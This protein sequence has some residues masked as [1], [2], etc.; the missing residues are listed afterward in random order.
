MMKNE[1]FSFRKRLISFKYALKGI[2]L[3]F[4]YEHNARVHALI[5]TCSIITGF[6][7]GISYI[8][9]IAVILVIGT[10]LAAET[11][12]SA[13]EKLSNIVSPEYNE[14]IKH[15]KDLAAGAVLFTALAAAF[16][17]IIIFLPKVMAL[18]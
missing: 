17:G 3:L 4:R 5:S 12:N 13:I 11:F 10:V 14:A 8:E 1:N 2:Y 6:F 16:I 18:C 15:I 9:W 7:F